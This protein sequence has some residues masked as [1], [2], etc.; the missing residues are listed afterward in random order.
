MQIVLKSSPDHE[1]DLPGV[2]SSHFARLVAGHG[3]I[4]VSR[5]F[6]P[7]TQGNRGRMFTATVADQVEPAALRTLLEA[8]RADAAVEYAEVAEAK[9]PM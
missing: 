1:R 3:A 5:V 2:V 4:E 9:K 6:P 7:G 8:L